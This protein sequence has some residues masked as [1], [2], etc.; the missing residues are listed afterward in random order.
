MVASAGSIIFPQFNLGDLYYR[1]LG[2]P[3]DNVMAY[4]WFD[5][6]AAQGKEN[7][8]TNRDVWVA[9]RMTPGQIA[10]AQ[11]LARQWKP[12]KE[13]SVPAGAH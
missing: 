5:L 9:R 10:E 1:G 11:K 12:R 4:M 7:A 3:Q 6:A 8:G 13:E 2:V